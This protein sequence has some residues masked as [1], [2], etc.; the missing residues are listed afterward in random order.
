MRR[1][2][3]G[4]EGL[5]RSYPAHIPCTLGESRPSGH[6]KWVGM[7]SICINQLDPN[8]RNHQVWLM[9]KIYGL[10]DHIFFH[11]G[12]DTQI[13][14]RDIDGHSRQNS[15]RLWPRWEKVGWLK[16]VMNEVAHA[17]HISSYSKRLWI[18]Q[19][20]VLGR[21]VSFVTNDCIIPFPE[22][23]EEA[24]TSGALSS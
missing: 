21:Q 6:L 14:Q 2:E 17:I 24:A 4:Q 15:M 13:A 18:I 20:L 16:M 7:V 10:T 9:Q 11:I 12:P 8:E 1:M 3:K 19:E 23:V 5:P 22:L